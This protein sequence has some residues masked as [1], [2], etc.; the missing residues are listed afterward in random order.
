MAKII[1][2]PQ[3]KEVDADGHLSILQ[4]AQKIGLPLQFTCRRKSDFLCSSLAAVKR[5]AA[6]ARLL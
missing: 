4:L 2:L 1:F 6:N 3:G 5:N